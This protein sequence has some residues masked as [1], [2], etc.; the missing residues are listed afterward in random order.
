[1]SDTELP[2]V[3]VV[4]ALLQPSHE[5]HQIAAQW[6][7]SVS[8]FATTPITELGTLRLALN[9]RLMGRQLTP[10][11]ALA[12]IASLRADPRSRFVVDNASLSDPLIDLRGLAGHR[13]VTGL[14]LVDLA[15]RNHLVLV[16]LD[17]ALPA[18]LLSS[19]RRHVRLLG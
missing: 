16:T 12:S 5:A 1:M 18:S 10:S 13:Q 14:H 19:D 4:F 17:R 9:P 6:F 2:D 11:T 3:N 7:A 8:Q 15:A